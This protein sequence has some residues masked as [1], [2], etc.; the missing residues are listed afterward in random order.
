MIKGLLKLINANNSSLD[1]NEE[2][3]KFR[4]LI[5][6]TIEERF[7]DEFSSN[8]YKAAAV[9]KVCNLQKWSGR[10]YSKG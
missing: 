7:K 10:N 1:T 4:L 5:N 9:L 3:R 8:T 2:G 6:Y